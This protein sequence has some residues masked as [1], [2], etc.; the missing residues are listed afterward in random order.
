MKRNW[1]NSC[2][3]V[4]QNG[5]RFDYVAKKFIFFDHK[6]YPWR[7]LHGQCLL[8]GTYDFTVYIKFKTVGIL[9]GERAKQRA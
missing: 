9:K 1:L 8:Q 5:S 6:D 7:L 2:K 4:F 3:L